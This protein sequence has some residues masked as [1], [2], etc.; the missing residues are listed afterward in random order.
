MAIASQ[1]AGAAQAAMPLALPKQRP[2]ALPKPQP[3]AL[4]KPQPSA[5]DEGAGAAQAA[6]VGDGGDHGPIKF[7]QAPAEAWRVRATAKYSRS[8]ARD[9]SRSPHAAEVGGEDREWHHCRRE[10][11]SMREQTYSEE[12][13][14]QTVES[15]V[16]RFAHAS[17]SSSSQA[18]PSA[19]STAPPAEEEQAPSGVSA[20]DRA[21]MEAEGR[22]RAEAQGRIYVGYQ[23]TYIFDNEGDELDEVD[24]VALIRNLLGPV[25]EGPMASP[26]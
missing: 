9:R 26:L 22:A 17:S 2:L 20:S 5:P 21:L 7:K 19:S 12:E 10:V 25:C 13:G 16:E 3:L 24:K 14:L 8:N 4:P 1:A 11:W 18:R 15:Y 6:T 23:D